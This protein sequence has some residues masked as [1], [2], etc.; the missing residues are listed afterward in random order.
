M[1]FKLVVKEGERNAALALK[2]RVKPC[3]RIAQDLF[4]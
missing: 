1:S 3:I 2:L 4:Q